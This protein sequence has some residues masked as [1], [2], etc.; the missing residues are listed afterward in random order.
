L[1]R[2]P[3]H[4]VRHLKGAVNRRS[5]I[6]EVEQAVVGDG[7]QGIHL[8]DQPVDTVFSHHGA[9]R[10]LEGEWLGAHG[11]GERA[12]LLGKLRYYRSAASA[13]ATAHAGGEEHHIRVGNAA[14]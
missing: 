12:G 13:G 3:E 11:N 4:I 1:D 2:V 5:L 9:V 7:N 10:S 14:A 8:I 6:A